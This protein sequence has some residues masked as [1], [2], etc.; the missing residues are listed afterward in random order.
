MLQFHVLLDAIMVTLLFYSVYL[1]KEVAGDFYVSGNYSS[2][3]VVEEATYF[4]SC[5]IVS[6][7]S[8]F[9]LSAAL[10][11]AAVKERIFL[12]VGSETISYTTDQNS[13]SSSFRLVNNFLVLCNVFSSITHSFSSHVSNISDVLVKSKISLRMPF[14]KQSS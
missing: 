12:V 2:T 7:T 13:M 9:V 6:F 14:D 8:K 11:M 5:V 10:I 1:V 3:C 4:Y